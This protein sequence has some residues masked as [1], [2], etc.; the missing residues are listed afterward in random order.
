[1]HAIV[2][3]E[4]VETSRIEESKAPL[5][6]VVPRVQQSP[7]IVTG[8]WTM[9]EEGQTLNMLVYESEKDARAA[10]GR[11][12]NAPRPDFV[13]LESVEVVEVLASF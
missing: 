10:L 4:G 13:H 6:H 2:V 9:D 8:Y 1:M 7:G 11:I 5:E 3:R 12:Q